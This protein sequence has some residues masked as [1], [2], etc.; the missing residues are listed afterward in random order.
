MG[1]QAL[2]VSSTLATREHDRGSITGALVLIYLSKKGVKGAAPSLCCLPLPRERGGH[3]RNSI[4]CNMTTEL[5]DFYKT[6]FLTGGTPFLR[7][8]F[9]KIHGLIFPQIG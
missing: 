1:P 6:L 3:H 5:E 7:K 4:S 8:D 9:L 2:G